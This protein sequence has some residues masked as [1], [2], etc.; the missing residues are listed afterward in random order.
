M[1][2]RWGARALVAGLIVQRLGEVRFAK[3]N[4]RAAREAGAVEHGAGHYP[5][6]FVLHPAWLAG[7]LWESRD[8]QKPVRLGWLAVAL[9]AQPARV[10]TMRAL[11]PQWTTRIL[12]TPGAPRVTSGPYRWTRHPAYIAVTA[13]LLATPL[14]VRAPRTALL[15]TV[16]N[17]L[18]LGLVRIPAEQRAE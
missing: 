13:E 7:L 1:S 17:A 3:A 4:E 18:L 6:F 12:I 16:A 9:L 15:G 8:Q 10:A 14:A 2:A 5:L 11:G